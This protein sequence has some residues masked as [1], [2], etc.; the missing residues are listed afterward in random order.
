MCEQFTPVLE[1]LRLEEH[2]SFGTFGV[3]RINK[4]VF[5]VTLEPPDEL[6]KT[7]KSSI[8]AQQYM[9][10]KHKSPKFG[11]TFKVVNVPG[12]ADVLFHSGNFA[13]QTEGCILLAQYFGKLKG[14]RGVLNSGNTFDH[15]ME[16]MEKVGYFHLTIYE[17]Y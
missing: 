9:C 6:N 1:I 15:F 10:I 14:N 11:N 2:E 3:L 8:P 13:G 16:I 4:N 12:R 5:C 17:N 7:G